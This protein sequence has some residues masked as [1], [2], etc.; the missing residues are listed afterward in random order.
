MQDF[1]TL[2]EFTLSTFLLKKKVIICHKVISDVSMCF[3]CLIS[4]FTLVNSL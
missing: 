2:F 4:S 3:L 1:S